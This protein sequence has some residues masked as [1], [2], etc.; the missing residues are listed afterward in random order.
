MARFLV[1]SAGTRQAAAETL[2]RTGAD[3]QAEEIASVLVRRAA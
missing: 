3:V 2:R 1:A